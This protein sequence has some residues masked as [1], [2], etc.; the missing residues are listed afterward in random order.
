MD[1]I[2]E[3]PECQDDDDLAVQIDNKV[4]ALD[5]NI[6]PTAIAERP[7]DDEPVRIE[8][9]AGMAI[10]DVDMP[11][12]DP[13]TKSRPA[14]DFVDSDG[15][16]EFDDEEDSIDPNQLPVF[17]VE[18]PDSSEQVGN[19]DKSLSLDADKSIE[20]DIQKSGMI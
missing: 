1:E 17:N 8:M 12:A 5:L 6:K 15:D 3:I 14:S 19:N 10:F 20:Q 7:A 11:E 16:M 9:M 2:F 13:Q 4:E 18:N